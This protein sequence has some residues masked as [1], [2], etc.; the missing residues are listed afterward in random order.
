MTER[1][2]IF[3][4]EPVIADGAPFVPLSLEDIYNVIETLMGLDP[5]EDLEGMQRHGPNSRRV[6]VATKTCFIWED[7]ELF[8]FINEEYELA[9]GKTVLITRPYEDFTV[10]HISRAPM[11]W[12]ME[13]VK[14][15]FTWYGD[16]THL[17][18]EIYKKD[19]R[20]PYNGLK[21][22]N[23]TLKMKVKEHMPSTLT[24][25]GFKVEIFYVGQKPTCWRCG[26]EHRKS[27]CKTY[28]RNFVNSFHIRDFPPLGPP[29]PAPA[30]R[31]AAAPT[32]AAGPVVPPPPPADATDLTVEEGITTVAATNAEE[33]ETSLNISM[34]SFEDAPEL[35]E[36]SEANSTVIESVE[37]EIVS[38]EITPVISTES[39]IDSIVTVASVISTEC[40]STLVTVSSVIENNTS[41]TESQSTSVTV[42]A[43]SVSDNNTSISMALSTTANLCSTTSLPPVTTSLAS[44]ASLSTVTSC[45]TTV[46]S[47]TTS[48]ASVASVTS[49]AS[50]SSV[51]LSSVLSPLSQDP[52]DSSDGIGTIERAWDN[53]SPEMQVGDPSDSSD[54]VGTVSRAW[55]VR[56]LV[57]IHHADNSQNVGSETTATASEMEDDHLITPA[58][59]QN[60]DIGGTPDEEMITVEVD[61]DQFKEIFKD[62]GKRVLASSDEDNSGNTILMRAG[63]FVNS[64]MPFGSQEKKRTKIEKFRS[65]SQDI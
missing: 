40:Q 20:D 62:E 61:S 11:F 42:T 6:D 18:K 54:G 27:E 23:W 34:D 5:A 16:V 13:Y 36:I 53:L 26:M 15:V 57:D 12:N 43:S 30:A 21:T 33:N 55:S 49:V 50:L 37:S 52:S 41:S 29:R 35:Q 47:V 9:N 63:S 14:R 58:Q 39:E 4:I 8:D 46:S 32:P 38:E 19:I 25:S 44:V 65:K 51:P 56:N 7:K 3:G 1:L 17:H 22:G 48:L 60:I 64:L 59:R 24:V 2:N 45:I 10:V 28:Q 31:P